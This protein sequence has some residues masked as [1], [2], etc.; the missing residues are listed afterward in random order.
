MST[1][2]EDTLAP[3]APDLVGLVTQPLER[4]LVRT[5]EAV[6]AS[7]ALSILDALESRRLQPDAADQA[8]T[9]LDVYLTDHTELPDLSPDAQELV[10][11][12][13]HL[14]HF[15]EALGPAARELRNLAT[16]LLEQTE[17]SVLASRSGP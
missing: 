11:Q 7:L 2:T 4:G 10:F 17:R 1:H 15:G 5:A 3:L 14:H 9:M 12:G 6:L 13:E 16:R 8:F